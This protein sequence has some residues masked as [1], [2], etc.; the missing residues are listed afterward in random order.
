MGDNETFSEQKQ[1]HSMWMH[2]M[3]GHRSAG[4]NNKQRFQ[5]E[6]SFLMSKV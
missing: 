2:A 6:I 5:G 1:H 4:R 3:L